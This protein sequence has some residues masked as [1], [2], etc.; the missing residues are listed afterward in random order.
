MLDK[1]YPLWL[2]PGSIRSLIALV[3]VIAAVIGYYSNVEV[4][5]ELLTL[6]LGFYFLDRSTSNER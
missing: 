6:V 3:L 5:L 2:P 1:N 4:P